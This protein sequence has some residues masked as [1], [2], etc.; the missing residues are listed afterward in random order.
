M[1]MFKNYKKELEEQKVSYESTITNLANEKKKILL[2][3]DIKIKE[4]KEKC[5][6]TEIKYNYNQALMDEFVIQRNEGKNIMQSSVE[7]INIAIENISS[8]GEEI[9]ASSEELTATAEEISERVNNSYISAKDSGEVMKNFS[10]EINDID[11]DINELFNNK[12]IN[13]STII[14]TIQEIASQTNLL[15]LNASIE[16]ARAGEAGKGF[17]V[18]ASEIR[19]LAEQAKNSSIEIKK[20]ISGIQTG[21]GD[22]LNKIN[23]CNLQ[24]KQL[25]DEDIKTIDNIEVIDSSIKDMAQTTINVSKA[26][27]EQTN[28]TLEI[29]SKVEQLDKFVKEK[30]VNDNIT[31]D[32]KEDENAFEEN[33][34]EITRQADDVIITF[35]GFLTD[36]SMQQY[37]VDYNNLK[38]SVNVGNTILVLNTEKL[39][40]F[41]KE[42]EDDLGKFYCDYTNFKK[43]YMIIGDNKASKKQFERVWRKF[44]IIDKFHFI[45]SIDDIKNN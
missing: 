4:L 45:D 32:L 36:E 25:L 21:T 29:S 28:S 31:Q 11:E 39:S 7:E 23:N 24:C 33:R 20:I 8:V 3:K 1:G 9:I 18:I 42:A 16:S 22:I 34:Y 41:P 15:S 27:E 43:V 19:K 38:K 10:Q 5:D 44:N 13:I 35:Y 14:E 6:K 26:I 12:M 40:L 30:L 2:E 37:I 17:S